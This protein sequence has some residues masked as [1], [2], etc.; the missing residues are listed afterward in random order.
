MF[1]AHKWEFHFAISQMMSRASNTGP[2]VQ[3]RW[4]S[5]PLPVLTGIT[6]VR[7][8]PTPQHMCSS[9]ESSAGTLNSSAILPTA[10]NMPVGPQAKIFDF[11]VAADVRRL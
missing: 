6:Q 7:Q 3:V 2:S 9:I 4:Y 5:Q 1:P 10:F 11:S 8:T